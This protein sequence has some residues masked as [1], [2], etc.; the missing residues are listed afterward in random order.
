MGKTQKILALWLAAALLA[1]AVGCSGA[2]APSAAPETSAAVSGEEENSPAVTFTDALGNQ[3]TVE[4]PQRVVSFYG[5]FAEMWVLAGGSLVGTTEDAITERQLDLGDDVEIIGTVKKPN[6]EVTLSLAPDLVLLSAD[7]SEHVQAAETLKAAGIPYAFFRVDY[8]EDY[9][10]A[11]KICTDI[12]GR[13]DLYEKNALAV[14]EQAQAVVEKVKDKEGPKVLLI[15]AYST[16]AKAKGMDNLAGVILHQL[17]AHNIADDHPSLLEDLSME[18]IIAEDPDFIFV[19]IMGSSTQKA[20]DALA[21]GIQ[22]N[23]AWGN[24]S[25]VK[26]DRYIVL[27]S[28]LFHYKPNARWGESYEYL[29]KI[30]YPQVMGD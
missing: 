17:G 24:L 23:P 8:L 1:S 14:E 28:D 12:T 16:G 30:L 15:R 22:S 13:P 5:S 20:L 2:G 7:T 27:P 6:L 11:M 4:N 29:A 26:N 21:E 3:V 10:A 19:T 18:E 9:V 25:A